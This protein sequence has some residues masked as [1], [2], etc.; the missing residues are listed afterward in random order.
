MNNIIKHA[1]AHNVRIELTGRNGFVNLLI[2]DDGKGFDPNVRRK[3]VGLSNIL[4]RI[5]VF[6]GNLEL[7][8]SQGT[9]C[10][11]KVKMPQQSHG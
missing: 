8:T 10:T 11:L 7:I 6:D 5:E 9:G 2:A 3:G 1:D 4:S